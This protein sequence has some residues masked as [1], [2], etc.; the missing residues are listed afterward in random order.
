MLPSDLIKYT[1]F[2]ELQFCFITS[3]KNS[4]S[5]VI[6]IVVL[7]W[8]N[9]FFNFSWLLLFD[10]KKLYLFDVFNTVKSSAALFNMLKLLSIEAWMFWLFFK[11]CSNSTN[12][13]SSFGTTN[14]VFSEVL[15]SLIL[16]FFNDLPLIKIPS[17]K[18]KLLNIKTL[19]LIKTCKQQSFLF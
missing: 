2:W 4:K 9:N 18:F 15:S 13:K 10:M 19:I 12:W 16:I 14:N 7:K 6:E 1:L 8:L 3:L 5:E 11:S 17:S